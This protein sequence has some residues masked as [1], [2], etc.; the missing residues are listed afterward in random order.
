MDLL[1]IRALGLRLSLFFF[2]TLDFSFVLL[3]GVLGFPFQL[4]GEFECSLGEFAS[5]L[6]VFQWPA[7]SRQVCSNWATSFF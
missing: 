6:F 7:I 1:F 3:D 2:E 5:F 4:F